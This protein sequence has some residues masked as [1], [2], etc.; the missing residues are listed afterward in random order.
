MVVCHRLPCSIAL[1][2]V[3]G[4]SMASYCNTHIYSHRAIFPCFAALVQP[5]VEY[6]E[7]GEGVIVTELGE[8][9]TADTKE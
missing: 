9:I 5:I 6:R 7:F 8:C 1:L 3:L 4:V 2:G